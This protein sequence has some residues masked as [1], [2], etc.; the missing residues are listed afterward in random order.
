MGA[1]AVTYLI[2]IICLVA[3]FLAGGWAGVLGALAGCFIWWVIYETWL[4]V[5]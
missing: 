3:V 5:W 4:R 1:D 2:P